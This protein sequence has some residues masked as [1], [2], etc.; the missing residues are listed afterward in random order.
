MLADKTGPINISVKD[1]QLCTY[2]ASTGGG[3][4]D[5]KTKEE[6]SRKKKC[7]HQRNN[8]ESSVNIRGSRHGERL[9]Y[10]TKP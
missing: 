9:V 2:R 5:I 6:A 10:Q 1:R 7:A 8:G 4:S 3:K